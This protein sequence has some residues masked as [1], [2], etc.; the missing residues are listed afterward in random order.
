MAT[1]RQAQIDEILNYERSMNRTI[2]DRTINQVNGFNDERAPPSTRDIKF[3]AILG[4]L[5]DKLKAS[6][7]EALKGITSK[8]FPSVNGANS[9]ILLN[10]DD[11]NKGATAAP[12]T[13]TTIDKEKKAEVKNK[14]LKAQAD[15]QAEEASYQTQGDAYVP[16]TA[17]TGIQQIEGANAP[18]APAIQ[19]GLE[20]VGRPKR[21]YKR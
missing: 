11:G 8:Q 9:D 6:M 5:V 13:E 10:T 15:K 1:L 18:S 14:E 17:P 19:E 21:T 4:S 7:A 2:L 12:A 16:A 3:E 20:G